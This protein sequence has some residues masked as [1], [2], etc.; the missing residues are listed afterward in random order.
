MEWVGSSNKI[1][2]G[3]GENMA[4]KAR[5]DGK[6]V[7]LSVPDSMDISRLG[8]EL[9]NEDKKAILKYHDLDGKARLLETK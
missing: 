6:E 1:G 2:S 9:T 7:Y 4:V 8:D 3:I 5:V